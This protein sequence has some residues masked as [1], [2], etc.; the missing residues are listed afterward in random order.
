MY[1]FLVCFEIVYH[2]PIL[3][4]LLC[5]RSEEYS[6]AM[7][8][9]ERADWSSCAFMIPNLFS[10]CEIF[11]DWLGKKVKVLITQSCLT[12]CSS[13]DCRPPGSSVHGILQKRVLECSVFSIDLEWRYIT[14]MPC[15]LAIS[16]FKLCHY[17]ILYDYILEVEH[18]INMIHPL[19]QTHM[20]TQYEFRC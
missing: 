6:L 14:Y 19:F 5:W 17:S 18:N 12:L 16:L 13:M 8:R 4:G 11:Q 2:C 7:E 20:V 15:I 9:L 1:I 10:P 3:M